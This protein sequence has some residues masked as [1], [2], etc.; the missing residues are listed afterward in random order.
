MH[1][2]IM[3]TW[4]NTTHLVTLLPGKLTSWHSHDS[5][6]GTWHLP[7]FIFADQLHPQYG[8]IFPLYEIRLPQQVCSRASQQIF[9]FILYKCSEKPGKNLR[10]SF[11]FQTPQQSDGT[12][13]H[14]GEAVPF[15]KDPTVHRAQ[16]NLH[17]RDYILV[18]HCHG[19]YNHWVHLTWHGFS[20]IFSYLIILFYRARMCDV[21][22]KINPHWELV[23]RR[24]Q[25]CQALPSM[26][27][28]GPIRYSKKTFQ[29]CLRR[30][31]STFTTW[32]LVSPE[33]NACH[34]FHLFSPSMSFTYIINPF[35]P[36]TLPISSRVRWTSDSDGC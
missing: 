5:H 6:F 17:I 2:N 9:I 31:G 23:H 28:S 25:M 19:C 1:Q 32:H 29:S 7:S 20:I 10:S 16:K 24:L 26:T 34:L 22:E 13:W 33:V 15:H 21:A 30:D 12:W 4:E 8:I 35:A 36:T 14:P 27:A 18:K 3:T 11:G